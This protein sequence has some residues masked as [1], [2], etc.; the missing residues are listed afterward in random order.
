MGLRALSWRRL[1]S[2]PV[3]WRRTADGWESVE[4]QHGWP[5]WRVT[6]LGWRRWLAE[7]AWCSPGQVLPTAREA[8]AACERYE[9][10]H[11]LP[12][13]RYWERAR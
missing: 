2:F 10:D 5:V 7:V 3:G 12:D 4:A 9:V 6:R 13:G 11:W 8:R 1:V